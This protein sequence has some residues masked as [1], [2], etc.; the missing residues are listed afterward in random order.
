MAKFSSAMNGLLGLSRGFREQRGTRSFQ[1]IRGKRPKNK[2]N[3]RTQVI[4]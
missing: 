4:S 1:G 2:G 3:R